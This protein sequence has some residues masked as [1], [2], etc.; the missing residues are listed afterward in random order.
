[1]DS[2]WPPDW[3]VVARHA[4]YSAMVLSMLYVVLAVLDRMFDRFRHFFDLPGVI[5]DAYRWRRNAGVRTP[6]DPGP[7]ERDGVTSPRH[8]VPTAAKQHPTPAE[9]PEVKAVDPRYKNVS[10][11]EI[12]FR[13]PWHIHHTLEAETCRLGIESVPKIA[14]AMIE[15]FVADLYDDPEAVSLPPRRRATEDISS[16][17]ISLEIG[18]GDARLL[19]DYGEQINWPPLLRSELFTEIVKTKVAQLRAVRRTAVAGIDLSA[20]SV[21][22]RPDIYKRGAQQ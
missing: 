19:A 5:H 6:V 18:D 7:D 17:L 11:S 1:M 10:M 3:D 16:A 9:T 4:G 8:E 2:V 20:T 22:C 15:R 14:A 13:V 21:R 12:S